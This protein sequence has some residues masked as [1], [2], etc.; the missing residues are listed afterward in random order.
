VPG[1]RRIVV[2]PPLSWMRIVRNRTRSQAAF[3]PALLGLA[4]VLIPCGVTLSVEAL[5]LTSGPALAGL[6]VHINTH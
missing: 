4:T 1:F 6:H 3:A 2:E 5:A